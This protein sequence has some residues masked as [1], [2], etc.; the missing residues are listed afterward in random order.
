MLVGKSVMLTAI[1]AVAFI[2]MLALIRYEFT[3]ERGSGNNVNKSALR[4]RVLA[5]NATVCQNTVQ[6]QVYITDERGMITFHCIEGLSN[7]ER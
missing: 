4:W 1:A 5:P 7:R 2:V 6:G 3:I